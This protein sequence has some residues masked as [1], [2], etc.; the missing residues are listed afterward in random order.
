MLAVNEQ[1]IAE[2]AT[3]RQKKAEL[4]R[5]EDQ[6][7]V[8][9]IASLQGPEWL[10]L[11]DAIKASGLTKRQILYKAEHGYI[12]TQKEGRYAKYLASDLMPRPQPAAY[13]AGTS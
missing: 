4:E 7:M 5:Q 10:S 3:V 1:L 2:L 12:R 11:Q 13:A 6:L 9:I 8:R